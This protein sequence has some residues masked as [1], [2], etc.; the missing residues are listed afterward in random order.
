MAGFA[1]QSDSRRDETPPR[2]GGGA[3][4]ALIALVAALAAGAA[5]HYLAGVA[6]WGVA[7]VS[8]LFAAVLVLALANGRGG[9]GGD[10][11]Q[12]LLEHLEASSD[13]PSRPPDDV[14]RSWA[15]LY[16]YV[17]RMNEQRR[18]ASAAVAELERFKRQ[19]EAAASAYR[20]GKD[21]LTDL[22]ELRVGPL[23][24]LLE[25]TKEGATAGPV[26]SRLPLGEEEL[27][28]VDGEPLPEPWPAGADDPSPLDP[29]V[30]AEARRGLDELIQGL[31]ELARG[32][33]PAPARSS[34]SASETPAQL[35]DAVVQTAAD[36]IEDLAAGLMRAN[37]LASVAERVTN[38]ATLLAL[39][40][41]LEATRSGSEAFAAIAE[42]TRRLAEFAREATDT[43]SL[44][45][46]EI[47]YKVGETITA[48]HATSEHAK[49]SLGGS[50]SAPQA[51]PA[52]RR[53]IEDLVARAWKIRG[54]LSPGVGA[55]AA[56]PPT[57]P[58]ARSKGD[59]PD[60]GAELLA[61]EPEPR[62]EE[63][64]PESSSVS[65]DVD[66]EDDRPVENAPEEADKSTTGDFL[67]L[68][69]LEPGATYRE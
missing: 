12:R 2:A 53:V 56:I 26:V 31:S 16:Q 4:A 45:A 7:G 33:A 58:A 59:D 34:G 17:G 36:G 22:A 50:S 62:S 38:R 24:E 35:V 43:I 55:P 11:A 52:T 9:D 54:S 20:A 29:R 13:R 39:N 41:A 68:E 47:E 25:A 40:A 42:E 19:V 44:L 65:Y 64:V 18:T 63:G 15:P 30:R 51:P 14:P 60:S 37:E 3:V 8:G 27:V 28:G 49:T 1:R 46:S 67:M 61:A 10:H 5:G 66:P 21:P 23:R 57:A 32:T 48:I 6:A 69:G